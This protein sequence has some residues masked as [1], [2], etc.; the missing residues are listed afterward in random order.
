[1][2]VLLVSVQGQP[3]G[4]TCIFDGSHRGEAEPTSSLNAQRW[5]LLHGPSVKTEEQ[6]AQTGSHLSQLTAFPELTSGKPQMHS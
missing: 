5:T 4:V 6:W 2:G 1:M 3:N